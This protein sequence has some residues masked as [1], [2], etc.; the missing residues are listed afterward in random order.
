VIISFGVGYIAF[1]Q[2][3][4]A[5]RKR[6]QDL[7]DK[8]YDFFRRLWKSYELRITRP[9]DYPPLDDGDILDLVHEAEFLFGKDIVK[10]LFEMPKNIEEKI[11]NYDWFSKPFKKYLALER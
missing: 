4:T 10:H 7:F 3:R 6:R 1:Q 11:L 9:F 2:W 5:E 8:R